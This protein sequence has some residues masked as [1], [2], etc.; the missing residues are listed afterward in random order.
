[1][2][3]SPKCALRRRSKD[4]TS[5]ASGFEHENAVMNLETEEHAS[6]TL[7]PTPRLVAFIDILGF[8]SVIMG[9]GKTEHEVILKA[10]QELAVENKNFKITTKEVSERERQT[11]IQPS[12]T[13]FSDNVLIS[14]ELDGL[15]KAGIWHGLQSI[16]VTACGLAHRAREFGCLVRGAV[17]IGDLYQKDG[18]AFGPGLVRA[19][20]LESET[21]FY[22]R[23]IVTQDVIDRLG[24]FAAKDG[25]ATDDRSMFRD[26]DGYWCLDYMTANLEYLGSDMTPEACMARRTWALGQRHEAL[27]IAVRL[28]ENR[29][30]KASQK[31]LWFADRFEKSMLSINPHR[32]SVDGK[33]IPFPE[34]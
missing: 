33:P 2:I 31:W 27:V 9:A 1:M 19:Y 8:R 14:Y 16:R 18:V 10:L 23:V 28:A 13:S 12:F 29:H 24:A 4:A 21:A 17:M 22:P 5:G 34:R 26:S 15:G 3:R 20:E 7:H 32:F 6:E 30:D 25:W 11:L